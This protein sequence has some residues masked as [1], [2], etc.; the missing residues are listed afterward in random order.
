MSTSCLSQYMNH[1]MCTKI[2][3]RS[4]SASRTP[5][6][7]SSSP[8]STRPPT[9]SPTSPGTWYLSSSCSPEK[10]RTTVLRPIHTRDELIRPRIEQTIWLN[11]STKPFFW[12][13]NEL[14]DELQFVDEFGVNSPTGNNAMVEF[15]DEFTIHPHQFVS[16][17]NGSLHMNGSVFTNNSPQLVLNLNRGRV[18]SCAFQTRKTKRT[19]C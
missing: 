7:C 3:N 15:M 1:T 18:L 10:E 11:S 17:M 14:G 2:Y 5:S 16:G 4:T 13:L 6:T 8:A 9:G 12:F 19:C